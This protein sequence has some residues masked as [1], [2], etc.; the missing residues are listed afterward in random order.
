MSI[1][2]RIEIAYSVYNDIELAGWAV[3]DDQD[4]VVQLD[5]LDANGKQLRQCINRY[6]RPSFIVLMKTHMGLN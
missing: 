4:E 3:C 1:K 6:S 5:L 2:Y